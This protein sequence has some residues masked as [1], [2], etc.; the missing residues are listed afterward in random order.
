MP[1]WKARVTVGAETSNL[2][3]MEGLALHKR[4]AHGHKILC[5][6]A[7]PSTFGKEK[8]GF[9]IAH[10]HTA[11]NAANERLIG[12]ACHADWGPGIFRP[13]GSPGVKPLIEVALR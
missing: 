11:L 2:Q 3:L 4:I 12:V 7:R 13:T 6:T 5:L 1:R 8:P 10:I 9:P